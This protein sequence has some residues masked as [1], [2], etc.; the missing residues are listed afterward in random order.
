MLR[1][2]LAPIVA[3]LALSATL[4]GCGGSVDLTTAV[5]VVDVLTG[6]HDDGVIKDGPQAGWSHI[7]P[8]ITFKLK[9]EST[10]PI[11]GV[12]LMVSFWADGR[13]G[14]L[15]SRELQGIGNDPLAPGASTEPITLRSTV[16]FNLEAPRTE[17]FNQSGFVDW[18]AKLF[19]KRGGRIVPIGAFKI[20][21][22][23]L[24]R[25]RVSNRP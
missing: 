12:H 22:R 14:E 11:S 3:A 24:P 4:I 17:L 15:D 5:K 21:R 9:N 23:L 6:Y 19:A 25:E 10:G 20:D 18:T 7:L 13:D 8:S 1:S 2:R 16:G